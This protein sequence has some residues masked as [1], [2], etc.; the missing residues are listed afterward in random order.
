MSKDLEKTTCV[1]VDGDRHEAKAVRDSVGFQ[2]GGIIRL[3]NGKIVSGRASTVKTNS[4]KAYGFIAAAVAKSGSGVRIDMDSEGYKTAAESGW[5]MVSSNGTKLS[6]ATCTS[7]RIDEY[8][9]EM[10]KDPN[11][12]RA[13]FERVNGDAKAR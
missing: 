5:V 10:L 3:A 8:A 2:H 12:V 4:E 6:A 13:F 7:V 9:A 1:F 11:K